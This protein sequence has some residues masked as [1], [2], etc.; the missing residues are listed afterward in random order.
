MKYRIELEYAP[1]PLDKLWIDVILTDSKIIDEHDECFGIGG[2]YSSR[3]GREYKFSLYDKSEQV[4]GLD[5]V[6][7]KYAAGELHILKQR[8]VIGN[9]YLY[10]DA[11]EVYHYT[12]AK[13]TPF[14]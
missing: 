9:A 12:I 6:D 8:L 10:R 1:Y 11:G 5:W 14:S 7:G 4:A 13:L 2:V 3:D